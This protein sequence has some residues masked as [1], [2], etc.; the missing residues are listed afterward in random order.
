VTDQRSRDPWR[1]QSCCWLSERFL[2]GGGVVEIALGGR[3]VDGHERVVDEA[4]S[5]VPLTILPR[6]ALRN[7]PVLS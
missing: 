5:A 4:K 6:T 1:E 2:E 7:K 3:V